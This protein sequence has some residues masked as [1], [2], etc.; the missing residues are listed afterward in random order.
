MVSEGRRKVPIAGCR[1]VKGL[2]KKNGL[3]R[4]VRENTTVHEGAIDSMRHLKNEV[5]SIKKDVECGIQF[6]D[7]TIE[8]AA[9]DKLICYEK[10]SV[11]QKTDWDPGF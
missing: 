9:G 10:I 5:E 3:Y 6:V 2:L 1:C 8:F 11:Q 4:I 7:K